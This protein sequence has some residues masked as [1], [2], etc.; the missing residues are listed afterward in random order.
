MDN[1]MYGHLVPL[2]AAEQPKVG[3]IS[4]QSSHVVLSKPSNGVFIMDEVRNHMKTQRDKVTTA[5]E[6][7]LKELSEK[8]SKDPV[9]LAPYLA[10]RDSTVERLKYEPSHPHTLDELTAVKQYVD[11]CI[12]AHAAAVRSGRFTTLPIEKRQDILRNLSHQFHVSSFIKWLEARNAENGVRKIVWLSREHLP[13]IM[14][15]Y[16]YTECSKF[17]RM[18]WDMAF[19][20]LRAL[21]AASC[22]GGGGE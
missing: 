15:S 1:K 16:L 12:S 2:W 13:Q 10:I 8:A 6:L 20:I 21:K 5:I 9:L 14:A 4:K 19:S 18:P 17:S 7:F 3:A 22:G 11:M